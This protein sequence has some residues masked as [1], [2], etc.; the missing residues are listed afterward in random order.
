MTTAWKVV[1]IVLALLVVYLAIRD[2]QRAKWMRQE[3]YADWIDFNRFTYDPTPGGPTDPTKP[4]PP[5]PEF[6]F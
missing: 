6:G 4:P 3:L 1:I 2:Y 5:P